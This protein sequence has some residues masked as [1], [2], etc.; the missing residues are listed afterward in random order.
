MKL[1]EN[2]EHMEL[3]LRDINKEKDYYLMFL[4]LIAL[5]VALLFKDNK[6]LCCFSI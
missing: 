5:R 1:G 3:P 2:H 4:T 6:L